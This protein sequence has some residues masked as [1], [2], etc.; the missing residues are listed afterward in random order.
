MYISFIIGVAP[1]F[2][3]TSL[4][5][6]LV[7][8]WHVCFLSVSGFCCISC[9]LCLVI[10]LDECLFLYWRF[11]FFVSLI[12]SFFPLFFL[13]LF[14]SFFIFCFVAFFFLY[15]CLSF[16]LSFFI[17]FLFILSFCF[18]FVLFLPHGTKLVKPA[19]TRLSRQLA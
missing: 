12:L 15:V 16:F 19:W 5:L 11:S 9:F 4:F 2:F 6:C 18:P 3:N 17:Y 7:V 1:F 10:S 14:L 13:A 8:S